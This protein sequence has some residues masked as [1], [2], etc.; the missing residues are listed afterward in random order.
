MYYYIERVSGITSV[1]I[2]DIINPEGGKW[3]GGL[4]ESSPLTSMQLSPEG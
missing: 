3:E 2:L 4:R 1:K